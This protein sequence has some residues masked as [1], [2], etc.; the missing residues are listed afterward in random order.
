LRGGVF[1]V[2]RTVKQ[3]KR[4]GD[5]EEVKKITGRGGEGKHP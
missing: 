3:V 2:R 1:H 5:I 4:R